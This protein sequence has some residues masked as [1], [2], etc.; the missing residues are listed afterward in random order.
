MEKIQK[1][2]AIDNMT[3]H[4]IEDDESNITMPLFCPI[5]EFIMSSA[6]DLEYYHTYSCC[7]NCSLKFAESR[8]TEWKKGWRP[9]SGEIEE[10]KNYLRL[11]SPCFILE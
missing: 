5:C 8:K 6:F 11:Q 4:I 3:I 9:S 10:F 2:I 7:K 1:L